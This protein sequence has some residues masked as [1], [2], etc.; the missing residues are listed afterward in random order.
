MP[1]SGIGGGATLNRQEEVSLEK[2]RAV[3]PE[4]YEAYLKGRYFWNKRTGDGLRTAIKYFNH[5]I[6][7]DPTYAEAYSGLADAYALSG[8][9]EY[10]V[11]EGPIVADAALSVAPGFGRFHC[12]FVLAHSHLC[13]RPSYPRYVPETGLWKR[14]R[15]AREAPFAVPS[16]AV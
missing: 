3:N 16:G 2:S 7:V 12:V 1:K 10:G 5:A 15:W 11:Q 4:A 14:Y 6:E 13:Q 8:D 9:W